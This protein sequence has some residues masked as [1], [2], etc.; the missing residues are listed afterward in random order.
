MLVFFDLL[1]MEGF[2]SD[3]TASNNGI[4]GLSVERSSDLIIAT[5]SIVSEVTVVVPMGALTGSS[6]VS[7]A[8]L[9]VFFD[10]LSMEGFSSDVTASNNGIAG[11]SVERSSDLIIATLSI[12]SEVTVVVP[13]GALTGSSAVSPATLLVF[14]DLLSMEEFSSDVT[15]IFLAF[16]A[17]D[18]GL[19]TLSVET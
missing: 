7:P 16:D 15:A 9:L 19:A 13:M 14:F 8:T 10:L 5:L 17:S 11:L 18:D 1:S 4:A 12:V 2:S 3:V 6:A